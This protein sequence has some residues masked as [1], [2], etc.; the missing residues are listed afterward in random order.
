M[1]T[2]K[3]EIHHLMNRYTQN[4]SKLVSPENRKNVRISQAKL[5]FRSQKMKKYKNVLLWLIQY[6]LTTIR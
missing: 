6:Q 3:Q 2:C 1:F 4:I 5:D